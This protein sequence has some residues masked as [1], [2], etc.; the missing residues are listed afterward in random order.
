MR[1]C[2][3]RILLLLLLFTGLTY[4]ACQVE[5][6][7]REVYVGTYDVI[8]I[9]N[10]NTVLAD[11]VHQ[12][13]ASVELDPATPDGLLITSLTNGGFYRTGCDIAVELLGGRVIVPSNACGNANSVA[14]FRFTGEGV[15]QST[16]HIIIDF[17][18]ES[19]EDTQFGTDCRAR[20]PFT[21]DALR[22][23][24]Q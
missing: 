2:F 16:D 10:A 7:Y 23:G 8:E 22:A 1:T 15:V 12:Y 13:Q 4:Q 24:S 3:P 14:Y 20:E 19:C 18:V 17:D 5:P 9:E 11:T 21:F 6:D